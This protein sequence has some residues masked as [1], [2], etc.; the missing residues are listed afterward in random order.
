MF[1]CAPTV[2]FTPACCEPLSADTVSVM[3]PAA[4][5]LL[6]AADIARLAGVGRA[7]VSNWRRRYPEFPKP[8]GGTAQ[9]P[10]FAR[11]QVEGWLAE[12]G[13]S[14]QLA[15]A[16]RT[17]TGTQRI[18]DLATFLQDSPRNSHE[19]WHGLAHLTPGQLLAR[20][21]VSLLPDSTSDV[22]SDD[23]DLPLV[24]DP[25]CAEATLLLAVAERFGSRV[26]IEGQEI[27]ESAAA[28]AAA[29]LRSNT[30]GVPY[31]IHYA[32]S[33]LNNQLAPYVGAAAAVVCEPPFDKPQW[34]MAELTDDP[35]W[36]FGVPAPRDAELAWVQHCYAHLRPRGVAVIA[37]S[38]RTSFQPSGQAIRGEL[39]RSGALHSVIALPA[40]MGSS[41]DTGLH[42]W[43]LQ[44]PSGTS[45]PDVVA[46]IDLSGLGDPADVP[47]ELAAWELLG[48]RRFRDADP[49][50]FRPV[51][52]EVLLTDEVDLLPSRY[53]STRDRARVDEF[54]HVSGRLRALYARIGRALPEFVTPTVQTR[55]QYVSFAELERTRALQI[56]SRETTPSAGD[57][58]VRTL[59]RPPIVATGTAADETGVAQVVEINPDR[60][61]PHFVAAFLQADAHA[62]PVANTLGALSR[63]D[64]RRCR[65]PRL[66]L[67][68]QRRYGDAFRHLQQ[69]QDTIT[70][71][72]KTSSHVIDQTLHALTTGVLTPDFSVAQDTDHAGA[73]DDETREL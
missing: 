57:L 15:T 14:D 71:L 70:A 58:L 12:T 3:P 68:E 21:M 61:D 37:V 66:S 40:G 50:V 20:V 54:A 64:L 49:A 9:R 5:N 51:P 31:E 36:R 33:L 73:T 23:A 43:I 11:D 2:M 62:L 29:Q 55:H 17:E 48:R 53:V 26:R 39:V 65:I 27:D 44:R 60:L 63:D 4:K 8:V 69:L 67:A 24:L 41:P 18:S 46:M 19:P 22:P 56:L 16:G 7:A 45:T 28:S 52:R 47:D 35:R 25:A 1:T 13:K 30:Q 59:G 32:D 6:T 72:A 42:L 10:V 34:P 38:P